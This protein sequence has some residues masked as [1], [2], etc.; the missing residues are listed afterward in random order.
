MPTVLNLVST[1]DT[2]YSAHRCRQVTST[3]HPATYASLRGR[4]LLAFLQIVLPSKNVHI[5]NM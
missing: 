1:G 3:I 4:G 5:T 2:D